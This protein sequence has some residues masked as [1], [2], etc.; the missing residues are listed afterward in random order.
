M[1]ALM[2][3]SS[4]CLVSLLALLFFVLFLFFPHSALLNISFYFLTHPKA[5]SRKTFI[6][7]PNIDKDSQLLVF[8]ENFSYNLLQPRIERHSIQIFAV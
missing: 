2:S 1:A 4:S 7:E 3:F 5:F 6:W 8:P